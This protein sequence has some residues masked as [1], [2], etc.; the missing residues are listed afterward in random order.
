MLAGANARTCP[1]T[2][3]LSTR[4]ANVARFGLYFDTFAAAHSRQLVSNR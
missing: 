1:D 4:R 3:M 2:S